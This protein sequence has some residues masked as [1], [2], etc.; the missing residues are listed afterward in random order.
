MATELDLEWFPFYW[1]DFDEGTRELTNEEVG[2]YMRLLSYQWRMGSI[3]A[4]RARAG[5]VT[6]E[7]ISETAWEGLQRK[8]IAHEEPG[9]LVNARMSEVREEQRRKHARR[10]AAGQ[11]GGR[12]AWGPN[13][14]TK[15]TRRERLVLA[16]ALGSHSIEEWIAL[17]ETCGSRCVKCGAEGDDILVRDHIV[18]VYK[19]GSDTIDNI[20]PLCKA[21][22]LSKGA[23]VKD[24]R[25]PTW[26]EHK[27]F[28]KALLRSNAM[29]V[30]QSNTPTELRSKKE[31]VREEVTSPGAVTTPTTVVAQ[32]EKRAARARRC[33]KDFCVSA[34]TVAWIAQEMKGTRPETAMAWAAREL[35]KFKD[36]EFN[37]PR[38]DWEATFRNWLRRCVETGNVPTGAR[39]GGEDE[40]RRSQILQL[41]ADLRISRRDDEPPEAFEKRVVDA[42]DKR[43]AAARRG[44]PQGDK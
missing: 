24:Y 33:P 35:A 19:G 18:P 40:R 36:H 4:D 32:R 43:L 5:R 34:S 44:P 25:P 39:A 27:T 17:R 1:R 26:R 37:N 11:L 23:E 22:N 41:A 30:A 14:G 38:S 9:R 29:T 13:D 6:G 42:N 20:Q 15:K 2:A 3:P 7:Q 28:A 31:E 21:C 16:R 10:A 8:F 12:A